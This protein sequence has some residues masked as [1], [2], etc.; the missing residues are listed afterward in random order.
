MPGPGLPR[1]IA[2]AQQT[3][4]AGLKATAGLFSFYRLD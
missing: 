4:A 3:L 1:L 2:G